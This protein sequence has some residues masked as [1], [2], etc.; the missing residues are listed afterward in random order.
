MFDDT[1]SDHRRQGDK[2]LVTISATDVQM[3]LWDVAGAEEHFSMPMSCVRGSATVP[4]RRRRRGPETRT[5]ADLVG[6]VD[7]G[8]DLCRTSSC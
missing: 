6:E 4:A 2:K 3:M 1:Y 7:R 5:R 8:S